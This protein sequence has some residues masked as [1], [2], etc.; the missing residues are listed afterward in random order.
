MCKTNLFNPIIS[1]TALSSHDNTQ[2]HLN[3]RTHTHT[4]ASGVFSLCCRVVWL[5]HG[6]LYSGVGRRASGRAAAKMAS[7]PKSNSCTFNSNQIRALNGFFP[8]NLLAPPLLHP[9]SAPFHHVSFSS[10]SAA[11]YL[12]N[13]YLPLYRSP[14]LRLSLPLSSS[15]CTVSR[16][17]APRSFDSFQFPSVA[18]SSRSRCPSL[19]HS[20]SFVCRNAPTALFFFPF[21]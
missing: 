9:I 21:S 12:Y 20:I 13:Y 18:T 10:P 1:P 8:L 5:T 15:N 11:F 3:V 2:M 14:C 17:R 7:G 16:R 6:Q 4:V 19:S